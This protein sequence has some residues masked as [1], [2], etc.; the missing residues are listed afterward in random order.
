VPGKSRRI[1]HAY[2]PV[3]ATVSAGEHT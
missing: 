3:W 2:H 1:S